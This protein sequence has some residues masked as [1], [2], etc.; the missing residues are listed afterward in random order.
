MIETKRDP[1]GEQTYSYTL[2]CHYRLS[3]GSMYDL[4]IMDYDRDLTDEAIREG[5]ESI[6]TENVFQPFGLAIQ[7]I[8]FIEKIVV[9]KEDVEE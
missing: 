4:D 5:F 7:A 1:N 3:E 8:D 9:I 6:M 2:R